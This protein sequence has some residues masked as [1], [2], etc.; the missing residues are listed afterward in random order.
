MYNNTARMGNTTELFCMGAFTDLG[1]EVS[2]PYGNSSRYD[3]VVD[4]NGNFYRIQCKHARLS[5][6]SQGSFEFE[7]RSKGRYKNEILDKAY[8][9]DQIDYFATWF[10]G[11]CYLIPVEEC[12]TSVKA[13]RF[14]PCLTK[15]NEHK[16][17]W[18]SDYELERVIGKLV[19]NQNQ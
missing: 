17:N 7:T 4:I 13:L 3:F 19:E 16:A 12:G 9:K 1:Y 11:K 8:T 18:A 14:A 15:C 2:I 5:S 6:K 10:D